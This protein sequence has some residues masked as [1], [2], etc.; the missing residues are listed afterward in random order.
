MMLSTDWVCREAIPASGGRDT[1]RSVP[2]RGGGEDRAASADP[3]KASA[4][5]L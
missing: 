4:S 5:R 2:A 1:L 3:T